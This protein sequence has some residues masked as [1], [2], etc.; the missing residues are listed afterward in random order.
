MIKVS[1]PHPMVL[2]I[3]VPKDKQ[4]KLALFSDLHLDNPKCRRDLL[5]KDLD[6][7]Y[8]EGRWI[9]FNGD[10]FCLMQG[11]FDPRRNKSAI[12]SEDNVD[13]YL[14]KVIENT[15]DFLA[16][17]AKK[18]LMFGSGNHESA[19]LKNV[20]T[21]VLNRLVEKMKLKTGEYIHTGAY[22]GWIFIRFLVGDSSSRTTPRIPY[23]I[24]YNHGAGGDA[25]VTQGTIEHQRYGNYTE[26]ADAIWSGHNHNQYVI[27]VMVHYLDS[28]ANVGCVPKARVIHNIRTATYKQEYTDGGFHVEKRR[29]AKPIGYAKMDLNLI[30]QKVDGVVKKFIEPLVVCIT[31]N[32]FDLLTPDQLKTKKIMDKEI[33]KK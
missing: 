12:R 24:Y 1:K 6:E 27:P 29:R 4:I 26:G 19:I 20:E 10:T 32:E 16:P 33:I 25:E 3:E 23:K 17:Y 14:D 31:H 22:H 11:K 21:D 8:K 13:D 9:I 7:A 15:A 2:K 5:K 18:I 30:N 28:S